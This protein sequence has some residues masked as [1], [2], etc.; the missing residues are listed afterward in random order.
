MSYQVGVIETKNRPYPGQMLSTLKKRLNKL[1]RLVVTQPENH[2]A[3][4]EYTALFWALPILEDYN[5]NRWHDPR[6]IAQRVD[7]SE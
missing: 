2:M 5:E 7:K 1:E 3:R 4:A 6:Q